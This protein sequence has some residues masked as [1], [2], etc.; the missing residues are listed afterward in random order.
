MRRTG[1]LSSR[2]SPR[3]RMGCKVPS[4]M[5]RQGLMFSQVPVGILSAGSAAAL[6]SAKCWENSR[7]IA[8][9][10]RRDVRAGITG[11]H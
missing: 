3:E 8:R 11:D 7:R 1:T 9:N 5:H 6:S 2:R 4:Y 10:A